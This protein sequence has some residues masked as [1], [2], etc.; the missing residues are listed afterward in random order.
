MTDDSLSFYKTIPLHIIISQLIYYSQ[1]AEKAI[2]FT[3]NIDSELSI[4]INFLF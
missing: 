3:S 4:L 1:V 2:A